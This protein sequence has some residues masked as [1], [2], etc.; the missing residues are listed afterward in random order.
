MV[1]FDL[2]EAAMM[3]LQLILGLTYLLKGSRWLWTASLPFGLL[4]EMCGFL[5]DTH[6]QLML[7]TCIGC[8]LYFLRLVV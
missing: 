1:H 8:V 7:Q 6:F 4:L 2:L 5:G 3:Q